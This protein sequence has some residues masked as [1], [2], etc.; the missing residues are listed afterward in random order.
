MKFSV[1]AL[2]VLCFFVSASFTVKHKSAP[3]KSNYVFRIELCSFEDQ[4][5]VKT[6]ELL[7]EIGNVSVKKRGAASVYR[8]TPYADLASAQKDLPMFRSL[9]F[10]E[11]R[12][13]VE[14][15]S[16][17]MDV[18]TYYEHANIKPPSVGRGSK[19]NIRI[20]QK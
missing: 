12:E 5:P 15:G 7:R 19:S 4:V 20:Y 10:E 8:T 14:Y 1:A 2:T 3:L 11:A 16:E 9:G 6:V 17:V 18:M 13:I